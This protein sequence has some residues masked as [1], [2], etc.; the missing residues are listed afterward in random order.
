MRRA[1]FLDR[2]GTM[3][4]D[5]GYLS[6]H[7]EVHWFSWSIDAIRLLNRAGFLV[8]VTTNQGGIGLKLYAESFVH[9]VHARLAQDLEAGGA[10]VDGWF[11]CPHH[12]AALLPA[13]R[14]D[15]DCR[16]PRP[17]MIRQAAERLDIDVARSF[18]IGDKQS[19]VGLAVSAGATGILVRTGAGDSVARAHGGVVPGA[20]CIAADLMEATSW[21]LL[22]R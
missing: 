9:E 8:C 22:R 17:G 21:V 18:V 20:A 1:V 12:P 5:V 19:D 7:E 16:K 15:C 6:R 4:R 14:L 2:D 13:L 3:L 10:H 11:H